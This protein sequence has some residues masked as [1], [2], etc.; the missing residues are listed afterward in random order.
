MTAFADLAELDSLSDASLAYAAHG[1]RV[2]PLHSVKDGLCSCGRRSCKNEGK[3]PRTPRGV[4]DATTDEATVRAWWEKW[5]GANIGVAAGR[6]SDLVIIDVDPRHG[7]GE[8]WDLLTSED[9]HIDGLM[10]GTGGG[11]QHAY[12]RWP[13]GEWNITIGSNS[14]GPGIDHR[15]DGGYVVAPPSEH[16][17]GRAYFWDVIDDDELPEL[18][19]HIAA[20]LHKK[21][22]DYD[23]KPATDG[24]GPPWWAVLRR[25]GLTPEEIDS[26]SIQLSEPIPPHVPRLYRPDDDA[27]IPDVIGGGGRH[28]ACI[29]IAGLLRRGGASEEVL[30]AALRVIA[31]VRMR[32]PWDDDEVDSEVAHVVKTTRNWKPERVRWPQPDP[33]G[34]ANVVDDIDVA[35]VSDDI[36][37]L[38]ALR[39]LSKP[40][41][42]VLD[43]ELTDRH[44]WS[45]GQFASL[46]SASAWS[47][48]GQT[49]APEHTD[50]DAP[51]RDPDEIPTG[52]PVSEYIKGAPIPDSA[53]MP[54]NWDVDPKGNLC[55]LRE[56]T[57][58]DGGKGVES[59]VVANSP[60]FIVSRDLDVETQTYSMEIT[61]RDRQTQRWRKCTA[62]RGTLAQARKVADIAEFGAP[63]TSANAR[64]LVYW[65]SAYEEINAPSTPQRK[66][67]NRIGWHAE[68]IEIQ[69]YLFGNDW[70]G[71]VSAIH[72]SSEGGIAQFAR[73]MRPRGEAGPE[74][75]ALSISMRFPAVGAV[76]GAAFATPLLKAVG[77]PGFVVSLSGQ[78]STGKTSAMRVAAAI[79]GCPDEREGD[80]VLQTWDA[81]RT[82][83]ERV[84]TSLD[85]LPL[86]LDDTQRAKDARMV[87][88]VLYDVPSGR[89][90]GRATAGGNTKEVQASRGLIIS[91][92]E[93]PILESSQHGG[94][95]AR[96]VELW[97]QPWGPFSA[98]T[99][100][101]IQELQWSIMDN[102]GHSGRR[103]I[104]Y[105]VRQR[106]MWPRWKDRYREKYRE[107]SEVLRERH[108]D[109][110]AAVIGRL[111]E[112]IAVIDA[113]LRLAH[114]AGI[115]DTQPEVIDAVTEHIMDHAIREAVSKDSPT[116]ALQYVL[117]TVTSRRADMWGSH[118]TESH[119]APHAG[120][121]G[122]WDQTGST[123]GL[124][125]Q[126][127]RALLDKG[128]WPAEGVIR[129]WRERG[130]LDTQ[131]NQLAKTQRLAGTPSRL[132]VIRVAA[133]VEALDI[134]PNEG[135]LYGGREDDDR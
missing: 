56:K 29:P 121:L 69:G 95:R 57:H 52:D 19:Q 128:G 39:R 78:T 12:Y 31:A 16:L 48:E 130:W 93:I 33:K 75:S 116:E 55:R 70:I 67:S 64:D 27:S 115:L 129:A 50:A 94:T 35:T 54:A 18:P 9:E 125:P 72:Q 30:D 118:M 65:F 62:P 107:I 24:K 120:W 17:S 71:G 6:E 91:S 10:V 38:R 43:V 80:S 13:S 32:P 123:I 83:I 87:S 135:D 122:R 42:R 110:S 66:T 100:K 84:S 22:E 109:K 44:K 82:W 134:D 114:K 40:A 77:C 96:V 73:A 81:T 37:I 88:Q 104:E 119:D 60:I 86:L 21:V 90:R 98:D 36:E 127:L 101:V 8:T 111:A 113:A 59:I 105:L 79:Y 68:G 45:R 3:H 53:V 124:F 41:W 5:P 126:L 89:A 28:D 23:S 92:G 132:I 2:F 47:R 106:K 133:I 63:A 51:A 4:H 108:D 46:K 34:I 74:Q 49:E 61:W 99:G 20:R 97:G 85:G 103:W 14:L 58:E 25:A 11:G 102:H 7:G 15:G 117:D 131:K 112:Y 1:W 76:I 26:I